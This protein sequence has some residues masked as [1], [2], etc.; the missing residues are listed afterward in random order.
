MSF[1]M[2]IIFGTAHKV[3]HNLPYSGLNSLDSFKTAELFEL[4]NR[5]TENCYTVWSDHI[6]NQYENYWTIMDKYKLNDNWSGHSILEIQNFFCELLN[7]DVEVQK[8][9]I[10]IDGRGYNTY[11][12]VLCDK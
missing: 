2:Q 5:K 4:E 6:R 10:S 7:K 1:N 11:A 3:H 9:S 12:V 8:I